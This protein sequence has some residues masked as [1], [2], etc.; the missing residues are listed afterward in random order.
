MS[1]IYRYDFWE[2]YNDVTLY[3]MWIMYLRVLRMIKI[4]YMT[5]VQLLMKILSKKKG[6]GKSYDWYYLK[7][8]LK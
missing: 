6:Y 3:H 8:L 4:S 2:I 5:A 7:F 1:K